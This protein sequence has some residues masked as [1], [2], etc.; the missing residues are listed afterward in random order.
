VTDP[1]AVATASV[2]HDNAALGLPWSAW[3]APLSA[4]V[5]MLLKPAHI[6]MPVWLI[7]P[8][9]LVLLP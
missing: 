3:G 5:V 4:F 1:V 6:A 7:A 9:L 8:V 2:D